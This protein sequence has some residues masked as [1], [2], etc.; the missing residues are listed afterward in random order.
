MALVEDAGFGDCIHRAWNETQRVNPLTNNL[1]GR[2]LA[3]VFVREMLAGTRFHTSTHPEW[4]KWEGLATASVG[5]GRR[6]LVCVVKSGEMVIK[7]ASRDSVPL[8]LVSALPPVPTATE[9]DQLGQ[10][11]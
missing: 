4:L 1:V 11:Y 3:A 2:C 5:K 10:W 7:K 9:A 8:S 6:Q